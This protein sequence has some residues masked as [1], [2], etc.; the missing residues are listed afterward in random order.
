MP[1][2]GIV[3]RA[4]PL[5]WFDASARPALTAGQHAA[6]HAVVSGRDATIAATRVDRIHELA[7]WLERA[8]KEGVAWALKIVDVCA[9]DDGLSVS[10]AAGEGS[11]DRC[12]VSVLE[13]HPDSENSVWT[14]ST[15]PDDLRRV[16]WIPLFRDNDS[17]S[18]ELAL[19]RAS[20]WVGDEHRTPDLMVVAPAPWADQLRAA[21]ERSSARGF[22]ARVVVQEDWSIDQDSGS[23]LVWVGSAPSSASL[24]HLLAKRDVSYGSSTRILLAP[25]DREETLECMQSALAACGRRESV[26]AAVSRWRQ[27]HKGLD[28]GAITEIAHH[29]G[30]PRAVAQSLLRLARA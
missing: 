13:M 5:T 29:W 23:D 26:V 2:P 18:H 16:R 15:L 11:G 25:T 20:E 17:L 10:Y 28:E 21:A 1:P 12:S 19:A 24:V 30:A 9:G 27:A 22:A 8:R 14:A 7:G 6:L 4:L 3:A